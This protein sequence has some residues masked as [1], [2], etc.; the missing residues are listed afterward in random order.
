MKRLVPI[1]L[2]G[3]FGTLLASGA[4][5]AQ[6]PVQCESRAVLG[7]KVLLVR[8][9]LRDP[10][11]RAFPVLAQGK[12]GRVEELAAMAKRVGAVVAVNGTFF[13]AYSD[14]TAWGT[15]AVK[16]KVLRLGSSGAAVAI[17]P[18]GRVEVARLKPELVGTVGGPGEWVQSWYAWDVNRNIPDPRAIA[19]FTPEFGQ[20]V[21][22]PTATMVVVRDGV[23]AEVASGPKPVPPD[24]Y[25][26]GFGSAPEIQRLARCF[27]PGDAVEYRVV[28][29]DEKG[30]SLSWEG[31]SVLQAGPLLLKDGKVALD[32][33]L[34]G[35]AREPKF[36]RRGSWSFAGADA[37]GRLVL[38]SVLN[39]ASV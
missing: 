29:R 15:V 20:K 1:L 30:N 6:V 3:V 11:V 8:A 31:W 22:S 17:S 10:R 34:D 9:D 36:S 27:H 35:L 38:G 16:G 28:F 2:L 24:G 25:L 18:D 32:A 21:T 4:A 33:V 26:V 12:T 23:V 7:R 19:L 37:A 5:A 13:N 39:A 14:L